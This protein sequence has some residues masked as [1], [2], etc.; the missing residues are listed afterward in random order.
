MKI[1]QIS[2]G[3][4]FGQFNHSIKLNINENVTIIHGPNGVGKTTLLR[5]VDAIFNK[6]I[7]FF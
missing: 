2:V 1:T 5:L 7:V 4:L 3:K 6:N